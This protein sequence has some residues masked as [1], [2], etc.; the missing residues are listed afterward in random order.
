MKNADQQTSLLLIAL[1]SGALGCILFLL[2]RVFG[3]GRDGFIRTSHP[4]AILLLIL[5]CAAMV[6]FVL[7]L[8]PLKGTPSYRRIFPADKGGAIGHFIAAGGIFITCI[9]GAFSQLDSITVLC[10]ISGILCAA[11]FVYMGLCRMEK[12]PQNYNLYI[13]IV[14][15]FIFNLV[16][17]YRFWS[18]EPELFRYLFLL[19]CNIFLMLT[20]Y[21]RACLFAGKNVRRI[22]AFFHCGALFFCCVCA[23]GANRLYYVSMLLW[24]LLDWFSLNPKKAAMPMDL[25]EDVLYCLDKL[26][27]NGYSAYVVGGCVRDFLLELTPHDYDMCTDAKPEQIAQ[28]FSAHTLVRSGEKHGTIGVVLNEEVYEI[29]T[30]RTEG[31]YADGRHPDWV[32]FVSSVEEDLRRRDFTIN[33]I[34]FSPFDGYV[35]P[36]D[37]Q[38][39][40]ENG[41]LRAVGD[42]STRFREDALR[43]LRGVRFAATYKLKV[44]EA[45]EQAM[46]AQAPMMDALARE[47]V[48]NELSKLL[49]VVTA[50]DLIHFAPIITQ[51]IPEL[52]STVGFQQHSPHHCYDVFTHI[53]H[54]VAA[55]PQTLPLRLAAL[56]HDI[57]KPATFTTDETGRGHFYNHARVG[58]RIV[59][60]VLTQLKVSN[61]L[62]KQVLF[63][64]D[65]HMV[66]LQPDKRVLR[67]HI[68]RFGAEMVS[69]LL[70]LQQADFSS[71]GT[72]EDTDYFSNVRTLLAE[73]QE[74]D[75]C[76]H[77]KDLAVN[78]HDLL[79]LGFTE[80]PELGECLNHL[81]QLVQRE[82]IPN[83]K[84][85]LLSA[86]K[87]YLDR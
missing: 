28:I 55:T 27:E 66:A 76:L 21:Y 46:L 43:I 83:S 6:F 69:M 35:D 17:Q 86:A 32:D 31:D 72:G 13:L 77:L 49:L 36:W 22:Y 61:A 12:L 37:G 79:E 44:D 82:E 67:R 81:L 2:L 48:F 59:E 45:T 40:L 25:P 54:T 24:L 10:T 9:V 56:L 5:T 73:I 87:N 63:L 16:Q 53:A 11:G 7:A 34:A 52:T 20:I 74:E 41:L 15:F 85:Q 62:R 70:C 80:G 29:T 33:A 26:Q 14:P 78:G 71:K 1:E 50:E 8:L 58:A 42:P 38:V 57:G 23:I 68:G 30:F 47:R 51:I 3:T 18:N 4:L 60:D 39:D 64:V 75:A 65:N 84:E 19:L